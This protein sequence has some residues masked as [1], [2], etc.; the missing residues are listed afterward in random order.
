[1][2]YVTRGVCGQESCRERR[3][4]V[5]NGL[6]F[7]R[8]GHLQEGRQI[9][10]DADDFGKLGRI[11]RVK[12]EKEEKSRKTARG[13]KAQTLLLQAYQII[14]WKQC[15]ALVHEHGFPEQFEGIVH[16]LWALK[17]QDY[18]LKIT[19]STEDEDI[20]SEPEIFSS[21][22]SQKDDDESSATIRPTYH[23]WP[24]MPETVALC[25]L[26]ALIMQLPFCVADFHKLILRQDIPYI[27]ALKVVPREIKKQLPP[28][29]TEILTVN[30]IPKVEALHRTIR[31]IALR[32][33]RKF[34]M[35]LPPIN[36]PI[37][38]HR[39]IKR[40][41]VPID[42]Y[43]MTKV[44]QRLLGFTFEYPEYLND[45]KR[46]ESLQLPEIQMVVLIVIATKLLFP[47]DNIPRNPVTA[48]EPTAQGIDWQEW[49]RAQQQYESQKHSEGRIGVEKAIQ[50][51]ASDVSRMEPH[52][53]DQYMDWYE[54]DWL[55]T[56]KD[57]NVVADM[58]P[59]SET[60]TETETPS[61]HDLGAEQSAYT[62]NE[63]KE[64][65]DLLRRSM[66]GMLSVPIVPDQEGE[67]V[68]RPGIWYRRYRWVS[69]LPEEARSF[70]EVAAKLAAVS[71]HTLV[72][73][74]SAAEW[75]LGHGQEHQGCSE[76]TG[77]GSESYSEE[78]SESESEEESNSEEELHGSSGEEMDELDDLDE[79]DEQL[80]GLDVG[81]E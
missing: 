78:R 57:P 12:R 1:M 39:H 70:Y 3:Y 10:E 69:A 75:R 64:L 59:V 66:E 17:L 68:A 5:D 29:F 44:I 35:E 71:L 37:I 52:Q 77:Y 58:F 13:R 9:E 28:E 81:G 43:E 80:M 32:Y 65:D 72:R 18:A 61:R 22:A 30:K 23:I 8:R 40:L 11:N 6:W 26:A 27:R 45:D 47:F 51:S 60:Q 16:D 20:D 62:D 38:F 14:L 33:Q 19:E 63:E 76:Y 50:V 74:V 53:L 34:G 79:L 56:T 67:I 21:Q 15:Y 31:D 36:S 41:A 42:V 48:M 4:Y 46:I 55:D 2:D 7:C 54:K 24:R 25:Y 49:V 73:A